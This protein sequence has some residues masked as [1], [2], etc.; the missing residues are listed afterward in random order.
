MTAVRVGP[1]QVHRYKAMIYLGC[2]VGIYAGTAVAVRD[3]IDGD[4]F[5]LAVIA[6]LVPAFAGSRALYV[7]RHRAVFAGQPGRVVDRRDGGSALFGGLVL[8]IAVS[9][10]LLAAAGL[11]FG[12][13][14]D[15]ASVTMLVGLVCTR[16]GCL[17]NGC[18]G[19]RPT[20]GPIAMALPDVH[21]VVRRRIPTQLI[22]AGWGVAVL[23][24]TLPVPWPAG[25][26]GVVVVLSYSGARL[27][28]RR[29]RE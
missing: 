4:G 17:M 24:A 15:A 11:P 10:P 7:L 26:R 22:E 28:T 12:R 8:S 29:W 3:G 18:C 9:V 19:G 13:F 1:V 16:L 21:G 14:W 5:A 25:G 6:L 20:E 27:A 23:L 2:V